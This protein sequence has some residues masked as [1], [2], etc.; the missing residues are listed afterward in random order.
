MSDFIYFTEADDDEPVGS[1]DECG[2]DLYAD[3]DEEL[4][5]QCLWAATQSRRSDNQ[6]SEPP[7]IRVVY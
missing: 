6:P 2:V 5:E 4:C 7:P 3:D 1:C